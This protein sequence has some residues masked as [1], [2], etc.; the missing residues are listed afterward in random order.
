MKNNTAIFPGSF[1]PLT[2]GHIDIIQNSLKIFPNIIIAIGINDKKNYMYNL[3]QR[4]EFIQSFF[5]NENR[6]I[7]KEYNMLTVNF[8]KKHKANHIIRGVRN[9]ED[10]EYEKTLALANEELDNSIKTIFIPAS[11]KHI[12]ISSSIVREIIIHKGN[13]NS[14]LPSQIISQIT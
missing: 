5:Q 3:K 9:T 4:K 11:K 13:L 1:D 12:F 7:I 8:C 10:F 2:L 6:I 14:F